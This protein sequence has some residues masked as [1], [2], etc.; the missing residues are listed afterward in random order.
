MDISKALKIPGWMYRQELTWL[1]RQAETHTQIVEVGS[2]L[3]RSTRALADNTRGNVYAIDDWYGPRD[4]VIAEEK[5]AEIFDKFQENMDGLQGKLHVVRTDYNS[6]PD[7]GVRPD[8]VFLDGDHR[9]LSVH[10]D[11][12]YWMPRLAPGGLLCGH[13]YFQPGVF[14][15][16]HELAPQAQWAGD[17]TL[18]WYCEKPAK[19]G[20]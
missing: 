7:I 15:A 9:L 18:I 8:M 10:R 12:N 5:R 1:A 11:I 17:G 20:A 2:F 19:P 4:V 13:D 14:A 16:V 6:I 3:G